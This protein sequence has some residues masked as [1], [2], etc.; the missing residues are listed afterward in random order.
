MFPT[1]PAL[2][3]RHFLCS[4]CSLFCKADLFLSFGHHQGSF[5]PCGKSGTG[6]HCHAPADG[7]C[8][9]ALPCCER[10]S[11][12][13]A[14]GLVG[15]PSASPTPQCWSALSSCCS[16]HGEFLESRVLFSS[17]GHNFF[18]FLIF[19]RPTMPPDNGL[20]HAF[21]SFVI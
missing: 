17:P 4:G 12:W 7:H 14:E 3:E 5:S 11:A 16:A 6:F 2:P 9:S 13:E 1:S 18:R 19:L 15:F 10:T 21:S 8:A 20:F